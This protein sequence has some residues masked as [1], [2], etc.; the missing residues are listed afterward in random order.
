MAISVSIPHSLVSAH[1]LRLLVCA[2]KAHLPAN[3]ETPYPIHSPSRNE[4]WN[5]CMRKKGHSRHN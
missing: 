1:M 5:K 3:A 4:T 2:P